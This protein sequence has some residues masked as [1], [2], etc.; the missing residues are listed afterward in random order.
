MLLVPVVSMTRHS[1]DVNKTRVKRFVYGRPTVTSTRIGET[2]AVSVLKHFWCTLTVRPVH[3]DHIK[4]KRATLP[5]RTFGV[6]ACQTG[7]SAMRPRREGP[8]KYWGNFPKSINPGNMETMGGTY[9]LSPAVDTWLIAV[10][11]KLGLRRITR[12]PWWRPAR[13]NGCFTML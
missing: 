10:D 7:H 11:Y 4:E 13:S 9:S 6:S 12:L 1:T 5:Y 8:N 2:F 3:L